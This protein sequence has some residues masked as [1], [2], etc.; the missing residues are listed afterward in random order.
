[1]IVEA[2]VAGRVGV[3]ALHAVLKESQG[4]ERSLDGV[5]PGYEAALDAYGIAREGEADDSD[6]GWR[7]RCRLV[8]DQSV[9]R[10]RLVDEI[11]ERLPV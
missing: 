2:F 6:A 3:D 1:M 8:G 5:R 11:G 7:A 4:R 9:E 10:V